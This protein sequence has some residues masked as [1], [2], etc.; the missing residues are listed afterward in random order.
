MLVPASVFVIGHHMRLPGLGLLVLPT[1]AVPDWL[2]TPDLHTTL[3]LRL[4]SPGQSPLALTA[5]IEEIS[6][7]QQLPQRTLLLD[8]DLD[9]ELLA[10]A[11]LALVAN[12]SLS[13][14]NSG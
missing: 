3:A 5:T 14:L 10:S 12:A 13:I 9:D 6:Y 4:H 11:W 7:D 8:A 2:A 1:G